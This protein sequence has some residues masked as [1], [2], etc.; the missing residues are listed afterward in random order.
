MITNTTRISLFS[1][2]SAIIT[3]NPKRQTLFGKN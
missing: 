2:G 3:G 1:C